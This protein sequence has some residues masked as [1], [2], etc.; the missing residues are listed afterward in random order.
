MQKCL[1]CCVHRAE[2]ESVPYLDFKAP[3]G[4]LKTWPKFKLQSVCMH[5]MECGYNHARTHPTYF[6]RRPTLAHSTTLNLQSVKC[7]YSDT[8][9]VLNTR[10]V[11]QSCGEKRQHGLL[12]YGGS[13]VK[14][15]RM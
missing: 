1:R 15:E 2:E 14:L 5:N 11:V 4:L 8:F 10:F 9:K 12:L 3:M 7:S 6:S 13:A